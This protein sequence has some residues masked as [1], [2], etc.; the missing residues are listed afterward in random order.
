[1]NQ[2]KKPK[3]PTI[4]DLEKEKRRSFFGTGAF[5][6]IVAVLLFCAGFEH[7]ENMLTTAIIG[8]IMLIVAG[9]FVVKGIK[10]KNEVPGGMPSPN[11]PKAIRHA[12][13][14]RAQRVKLDRLA[15]VHGTYK[16]D[17]IV[18]KAVLMGVI[19]GIVLL[20]N[21]ILLLFGRYSWLA[22]VVFVL[23]LILFIMALT[24]SFY[25][26]SLKKFLAAG[27]TE[28]LVEQEYHHG[29]VYNVSSNT[30][31]VGQDY[32]LCSAIGA[33]RI[34]DAVWAFGR[35]HWVYNYTNGIYT[36]TTHEYHII[37]L[38][39]SGDH[40]EFS[41]DEASYTLILSDL[42]CANPYLI[43]GYTEELKNLY[44]ADPAS[45]RQRAVMPPD[46]FRRMIPDINS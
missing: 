31:C 13:K 16:H 11:S 33:V 24:G 14:I 19:T 15:S 3:Q 9:I 18:A 32:L 26:S 12:E 2:K 40:F 29:R 21:V 23:M 7:N 46:P 42:M 41:C 6:L 35:E 43:C 8:I 30:I 45:F 22:I 25:R 5:F 38:N 36:G 44:N 17:S 10:M 37:L 39:A 28:E 1:M 20:V 4:K 34:E 27:L